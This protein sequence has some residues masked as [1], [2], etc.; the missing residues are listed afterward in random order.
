MTQ[1]VSSTVPAS[2]GGSTTGIILENVPCDATVFVGAAVYMDGGTA[3]NAL[4]DDRA[5]SNVVGLVES[6]QS[7]TVCTVRVSGLTIAM[8]VGLDE[9]KNYY[10]SDTVPGEIQTTPPTAAGHVLVRVGQPFSATEF[11]V[12]KGVITI[13]N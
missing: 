1:Y 8:F 10:L 3:K 5:T 7:A 9:T 13:R 2:G 6:K 11:V 12:N 4:A